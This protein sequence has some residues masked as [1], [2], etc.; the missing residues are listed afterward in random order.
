MKPMTGNATKELGS[1]AALLTNRMSSLDPDGFTLGADPSVNQ[2]GVTYYWTALLELPGTFKLGSYAGNAT[3]NRALTGLG[4]TPGYV[5]VLGGNAT[6][7]VQR[8]GA[9]SGD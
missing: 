6:A 3:D 7:P 9:E 5:L 1:A 4:F 8:F 2:S